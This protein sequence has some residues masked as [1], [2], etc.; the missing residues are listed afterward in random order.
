MPRKLTETEKLKI[1]RRAAKQKRLAEKAVKARADELSRLEEIKQAEAQHAEF[2]QA[3]QRYLAE[4]ESA[5]SLNESRMLKS[6]E[7]A[8][9]KIGITGKS[10]V[11]FFRTSTQ[12]GVPLPN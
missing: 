12:P 8:K 5:A 11:T 10:T 1:V 3:R 2:E 4:S 9:S 6:M 7:K